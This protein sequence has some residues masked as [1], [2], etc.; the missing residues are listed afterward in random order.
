M[1]YLLFAFSLPGCPPAQ[2]DDRRRDVLR[3]KGELM[4][5]PVNR[6]DQSAE[7]SDVEMAAAHACGYRHVRNAYPAIVPTSRY[8][9]YD[10]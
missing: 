7:N 8:L 1:P 3:G 5:L 4:E 10:L 9:M 6:T 2:R